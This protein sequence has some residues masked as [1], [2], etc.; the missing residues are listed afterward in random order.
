MIL[1]VLT[2][3]HQ[4]LEGNSPLITGLKVIPLSAGLTVIASL[5]LESFYYR[6]GLKK[7][8]IFSQFC[9]TFMSSFAEIDFVLLQ[10]F[11]CV[12]K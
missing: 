9:S 10:C 1:A 12:S 7:V 3:Y 4:Y 11:F 2:Q 5:N 6:I 8:L